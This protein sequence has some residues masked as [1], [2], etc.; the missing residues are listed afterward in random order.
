MFHALSNLTGGRPSAAP[1]QPPAAM[2]R[3]S[4]RSAEPTAPG[5]WGEH[6][7]GADA[8][9]ARAGSLSPVGATAGISD[10][11]PVMPRVDLAAD[12]PPEYQDEILIYLK[13]LIDW[14]NIH[15]WPRDRRFG[16]PALTPAFYRTKAAGVC[17]GQG[18]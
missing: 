15:L 5:T 17:P 9:G 16:G 1:G 6:E 4:G 8:A 10:R 18:R 2:L 11:P 12:Q 7:A 13:R 3:L 14:V